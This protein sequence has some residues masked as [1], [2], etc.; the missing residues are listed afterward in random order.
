MARRTQT[1]RCFW[2]KDNTGYT[3]EEAEVI[4]SKVDLENG[5]LIKETSKIKEA[6]IKEDPR[7]G[8]MVVSEVID[9]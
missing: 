2:K 5:A 4:K 6:L 9:S 8:Y 3:H 1:H 7:G